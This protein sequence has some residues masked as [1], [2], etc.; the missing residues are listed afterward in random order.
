[1][2]L[3]ERQNAALHAY[4]ALNYAEQFIVM[5]ELGVPVLPWTF[6]TV[7]QLAACFRWLLLNDRYEAFLQRMVGNP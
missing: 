7:E 4:A 1:M 3:N 5:H 6:R 2:E